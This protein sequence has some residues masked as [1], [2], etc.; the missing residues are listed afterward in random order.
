MK[1]EAAEVGIRIRVPEDLRYQFVNA[2][3]AM[4]STASQELRAF[5]RR[6]VQ[7]HSGEAAPSAR[8]HPA[9]EKGSGK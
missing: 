5:M 2:C 8:R 6:F 1:R 7:G 9:H 3:R 4:D